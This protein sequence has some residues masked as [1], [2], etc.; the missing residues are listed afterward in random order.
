MGEVKDALEGFTSKGDVLEQ[1]YEKTIRNGRLAEASHAVLGIA[2][3]GVGADEPDPPLGQTIARSS[4]SRN[5]NQQTR[6]RQLDRFGNHPRCVRW[7][8]SP[9]VWSHTDREEFKASF[10]HETTGPFFQE[11]FEEIVSKGRCKSC[12][13]VADLPFLL[14]VC[15]RPVSHAP[16]RRD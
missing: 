15:I 4:C 6:S 7:L 1:A 2:R 13:G 14:G 3:F 10:V 8:T 11:V 12:R 9:T 5:R 16:D